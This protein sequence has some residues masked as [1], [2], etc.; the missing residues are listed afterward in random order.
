M[1]EIEGIDRELM[2]ALLLC[3]GQAGEIRGTTFVRQDELAIDH[4]GAA[5][6]GLQGFSKA[7]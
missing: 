4:C 1:Q 5:G 3:R 6:N 2:L 7:R